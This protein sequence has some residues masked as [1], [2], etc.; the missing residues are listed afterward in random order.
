MLCRFKIA[1]AETFHACPLTVMVET[2][3]VREL[4]AACRSASLMILF[5]RNFLRVTMLCR[6]KIADVE[7]FYTCPVTLVLET[8][9][10]RNSLLR[11]NPC[12][13]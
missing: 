1:G 7:V 2:P 11:R 8:A 13:P 10:V 3:S 6:L 9:I 5:G 4:V 12:P